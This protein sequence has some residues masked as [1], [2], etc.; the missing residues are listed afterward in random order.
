MHNP[1]ANS[2]QLTQ[3]EQNALQDT[4]KLLADMEDLLMDILTLAPPGLS[5]LSSRI[6]VLAARSLL[7]DL[8]QIKP[9]IDTAAGT[10]PV[11]MGR[12]PD[13]Y[14]ADDGGVLR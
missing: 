2:R 5:S 4:A 13:D 1:S 11:I 7:N 6:R 9:T 8:R 14:G 3:P 12:I 10:A